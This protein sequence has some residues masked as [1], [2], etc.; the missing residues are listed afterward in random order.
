MKARS[1]SRFDPT[2]GR[3]IG[4]ARSAAVLAMPAVCWLLLCV[5]AGAGDLS[6]VKDI[7][8]YPSSDGSSS[9]GQGVVAGDTLFFTAD[10]RIHG[11]ELW[12]IAAG[13]DEPHRV[14][15]I[16]PGLDGAGIAHIE[17]RGAAVVFRADDGRHGGEP[18]LSD[19]TAWG[20][21]MLGDVAPGERDSLTS[22][23]T[24]FAVVGNRIYFVADDG[25]HGRELWVSDGTPDSARMVAD[26]NPGG[27]WSSTTFVHDLEP[28]GDRLLFVAGASF[29]GSDARLWITDG[30]EDGTVPLTAPCPDCHWP[31]EPTVAGELAYFVSPSESPYGRELWRTD[32]TEAG[33]VIVADIEPAGSSWPWYLTA[34]GDRLYFTA[35]RADIGRELWISDGTEE[36]TALVVDLPHG[37][38][39]SSPRPIAPF[40]GRLLFSVDDGSEEKE[41]WITDGTGEGTILLAEHTGASS[42]GE[43]SLAVV[44]DL[45]YFRSR[46]GGPNGLWTTDGTAEGTRLVLEVSP[47]SIV[48]FRGGVFFTGYGGQDP[49]VS[50]GTPEGTIWLI[51]WEYADGFIEHLGVLGDVAYFAAAERPHGAEPW[52]TDGTI[53]GTL[54]L[55]D[56]NATGQSSEPQDLAPLAS[57]EIVF[58]ATDGVHGRELW[59]SDG[60]EE[61]TSMVADINP[62]EA[63]SCPGRFTQDGSG[64]VYFAAT[65]DGSCGYGDEDLWTTDGTADGT[66]MV[67]DLYPGSASSYIG[68]MFVWQGQLFFGAVKP[69]GDDG[70]W[71]SDGTAEGTLPVYTFPS[72][73]FISCC[74]AFTALDDF[75][76]FVVPLTWQDGGALWRSDGTPEGT[77]QVTD[78]QVIRSGQTFSLVNVG[79]ALFFPGLEDDT[80]TELWRTE[81]TDDRTQLVRDIWPAESSS[82][83]EKLVASGERLYF[84]AH[85]DIHGRELWTSDGTG[86][87]T[88]MIVDF[89]PGPDSDY[90]GTLIPLDGEIVMCAGVGDEHGMWRSDGT[91]DGTV[92]IEERLCPGSEY[93]FFDGYLYFRAW[94]ASVGY[95]LWR[96]RRDDPPELVRDLNP[97]PDSS[98]PA[99][100]T[101]A[102][103]SLYFTADDGAHGREL[104][105]LLPG[106][107]SPRRPVSRLA[108]TSP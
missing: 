85:E 107:P 64:L 43:G 101:V 28:F 87:G 51:D 88:S 26:L 105:R 5:L 20:T 18:W 77:L 75:F 3:R 79:G 70:L 96:M 24:T 90:I 30:T 46:D 72:S 6:L 8:P 74:S 19:G 69:G 32:G 81:G 104:W 29:E 50:D 68:S 103:D 22:D 23:T 48:P 108:P 47:N 12:A 86:D 41:L 38:D 65:A 91:P 14:H 98:E 45:V 76:V 93:A 35:H 67:L 71:R 92:F 52:R 34:V 83:P 102:G 37:G 53:E 49:W 13:D 80:G 59:R 36:G 56:L 82:D 63:S 21:W 42:W 31:P 78:V 54:L 66:T 60:S 9:P 15:D 40:N 33:T 39:G 95:E 58:S 99:D 2:L 62:G 10:D 73:E 55:A 44:G 61:G 11:R 84:T 16:S 100:L 57:G 94:Q 17:A 1:S 27:I 25:I 7:N 106:P 4:G 89:S 97:G